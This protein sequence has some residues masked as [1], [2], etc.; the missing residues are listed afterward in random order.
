ML[1]ECAFSKYLKQNRESLLPAL[2]LG[3]SSW[4]VRG[5]EV[6]GSVSRASIICLSLPRGA[7]PS[8]TSHSPS[9]VFSCCLP[10]ISSHP[11]ITPD[12]LHVRK[13]AQS[14]ISDFLKETCSLSPPYPLLVNRSGHVFSL[15]RSIV[16]VRG[17]GG[18]TQGHNS[19][20]R[21]SLPA[22]HGRAHPLKTSPELSFT[23]RPPTRRLREAFSSASAAP[24]PPTGSPGCTEMCGHCLAPLEKHRPFRGTVQIF[25][26]FV[27]PMASAQVG[28]C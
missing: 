9:L 6:H 27:T 21:F 23:A 8:R 3:L 7:D 20:K 22:G 14:R 28:V 26:K 19:W 11:P 18:R 24:V 15:C 12:L 10:S 4:Q 25:F 1:S 13:L 17:D 2:I 5:P 16:R